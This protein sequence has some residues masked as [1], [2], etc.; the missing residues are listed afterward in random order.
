M[1]CAL[2]GI[3]NRVDVQR[4]QVFVFLYQVLGVEM[5]LVGEAL[6]RFFSPYQVLGVE[7]V[8]VGEALMRS[9]DPARLIRQFRGF[10]DTVLVKTCGFKVI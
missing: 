5:V 1:L 2:S 7:M 10:D 4:Y 6:M 3:Q 8:L 9:A